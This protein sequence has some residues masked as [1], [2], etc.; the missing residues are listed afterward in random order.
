[1]EDLKL[2]VN[3]AS[4]LFISQNGEVT[5]VTNYPI[6]TPGPSFMSPAVDV[7]PCGNIGPKGYDDVKN[8]AAE[9]SYPFEVGYD[10]GESLLRPY[11]TGPDHRRTYKPKA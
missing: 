10:G 3:G 9:T 2:W 6:S 4:K 8:R 11:A 1:M 5:H 7:I